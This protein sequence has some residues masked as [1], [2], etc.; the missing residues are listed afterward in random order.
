MS[1]IT[2]K[3]TQIKRGDGEAAFNIQAD[4][5]AADMEA[6]APEFNALADDVNTNATIAENAARTAQASI[7]EAN[8][9]Q[10][11]SG[12]AYVIGDVVW[13]PTDALVYRCIASV[14]N[15]ID[16]RY[17]KT[18]WRIIN[19]TIQTDGGVEPYGAAWSQT[20][21]WFKI[22]MAYRTSYGST[23][24]QVNDVFTTNQH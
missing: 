16:P 3:F 13:S 7:A 1:R 14:T 5:F 20:F 8:A 9:T 6:A 2:R 22:L 12:S 21:E 24:D 23:W 17:D 4:N 18:H 10:W 19:H 11:I 15:T